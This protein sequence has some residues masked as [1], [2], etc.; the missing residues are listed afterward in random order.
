MAPSLIVG[1]IFVSLYEKL[2]E[3]GVKVNKPRGSLA[4]Q[5]NK[6]YSVYSI[7]LGGKAE[8]KFDIN[9]ELEKEQQERMKQVFATSLKDVA[10]LKAKPYKIK[11]KDEA[12]PVKVPPRTVL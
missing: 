6:V 5:N 2:Q 9:P 7:S 12:K 3:E 1:P 8:M 11:F 10:E 4:Q